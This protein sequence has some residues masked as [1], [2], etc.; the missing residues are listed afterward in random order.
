MTCPTEV[1]HC[2]EAVRK[3][4]YKGFYCASILNQSIRNHYNCLKRSF[5]TKI[6][7]ELTRRQRLAHNSQS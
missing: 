2:K 3:T 5:P 4:Y 7:K 1:K 6:G